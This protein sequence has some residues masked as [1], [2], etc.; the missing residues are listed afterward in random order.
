MI[1]GLD[2]T[3]TQTQRTE[4]VDQF[5]SVMFSNGFMRKTKTPR[6]I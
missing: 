6:T 2:K 3:Q 5:V 1:C 4:N